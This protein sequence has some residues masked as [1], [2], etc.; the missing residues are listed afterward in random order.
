M[1]QAISPKFQGLIGKIP[2][3]FW[4]KHNLIAVYLFG[5]VAQGTAGPLSDI[6]FGVLLPIGFTKEKLYD[7]NDKIFLDLANYI[8]SEKL[9]V[10]VL[11]LAP[12]RIQFEVVTTGKLIYS[13]DD[14]ARADYESYILRKYEDFK[15]YDEEYRRIFIERV[16]EEFSETQR[17]QYHDT[18]AKVKAVH[19]RIKE[20]ANARAGRVQGK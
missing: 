13:R 17:K 19:R 3:K 18:F 1:T 5:S 20:T 14:S 15:R 8:P 12:L 16:K 6:D 4:D 10:V 9:D 2:E 7:A 11:N